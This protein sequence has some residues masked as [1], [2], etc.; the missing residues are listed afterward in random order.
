MTPIA[1]MTPIAKVGASLARAAIDLFNARAKSVFPL[2]SGGPLR[3][4]N[5]TLRP[6]TRGL[7]VPPAVQ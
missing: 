6:H 5:R 2:P 3:A 7:G 1:P 4:T